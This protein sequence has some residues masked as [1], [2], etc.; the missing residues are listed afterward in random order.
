MLVF[1][2][3]TSYNRFWDGRNCLSTIN[4]AIR[5]LTRTILTHAYN[6]ESTLTLGEKQD[7]ERTIRIL[8]AFPYAIKHYL[9]AEWGAAWARFIDEVSSPTE[10]GASLG[11]FNPEYDSLLPAGLEGHEDEGLGLP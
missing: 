1:R 11:V 6:L 3:Q 10:Y 2:N 4:T 5:N 8:M 9:R 7:I